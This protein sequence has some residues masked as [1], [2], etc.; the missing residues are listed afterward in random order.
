MKIK[1][2]KKMSVA[3]VTVKCAV[4]D[5]NVDRVLNVLDRKNLVITDK[6]VKDY[7]TDVERGIRYEC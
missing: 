3:E 7:L 6:N 2:T 4:H 5:L 1:F